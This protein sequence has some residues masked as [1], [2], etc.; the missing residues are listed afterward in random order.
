MLPAP[1]PTVICQQIEDG[2]VLF[3]PVTE[4][5]FGL[6]E[7]GAKVWQLLPP[8]SSSLDELCQRLA[9]DYPDVDEPTIRA[10]VVE[11]LTQLAAE[12]LVVSPAGGPDGLASS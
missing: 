11:L 6:N 2:A 4:I 5:Y 8:V 1:H 7:V 10:D 3:A 9:A 12:G